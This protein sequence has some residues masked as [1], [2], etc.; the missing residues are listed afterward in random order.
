MTELEQIEQLTSR[1]CRKIP[2]TKEYTDRLAEEVELI[3]KH[4]FVKHFVRVH[5][6][7][8]LAKDF[9]HITRG[10]AGCSLVCFLMGIGDVDPIEQQIPLARFI[11]PKRDDL[12]DIDLDFPHWAQ[13]IVMQRI[14][15]NW[16][17]Q[18]AREYQ[19]L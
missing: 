18:S 5:Q 16:P 4:R 11:N 19:I 2:T 15:D 14:Y 1:F 12:P 9:P 3:L 13:A 17:R 8:E 10:S 7:L 6:I